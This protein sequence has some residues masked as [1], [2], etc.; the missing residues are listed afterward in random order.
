MLLRRQAV[1][2][3]GCTHFLI[4][5]INLFSKKKNQTNL[6]KKQANQPTNKK[7][8]YKTQP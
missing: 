4:T 8:Q 7:T 5:E 6:P 3:T 1:Y 2:W